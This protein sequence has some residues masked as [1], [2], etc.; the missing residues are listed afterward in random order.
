MGSKTSLIAVV[1]ISWSTSQLRE[2]S[3]TFLPQDKVSEVFQ[4]VEKKVGFEIGDD[5]EI[6][7][8]ELKRQTKNITNQTKIGDGVSLLITNP[9]IKVT[10]FQITK[11]GN[12]TRAI[13]EL[14]I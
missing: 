7:S 6:K 8:S 10:E 11:I 13:I 12:K 3:E 2:I 1:Q 5:I 4:N 14:D 9:K